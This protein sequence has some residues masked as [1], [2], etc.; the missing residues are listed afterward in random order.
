MQE[1]DSGVD[2]EGRSLKDIAANS[3]QQL[4]Q[5]VTTPP[6]SRPPV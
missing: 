1:Q 4:Q 2:D 3:I 5:Q 6:A